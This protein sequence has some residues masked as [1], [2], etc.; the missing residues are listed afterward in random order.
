MQLAF[1]IR[2][3]LSLSARFL[4]PHLAILLALAAGFLLSSAFPLAS[5]LFLLLLALHAFKYFRSSPLLK[6]FVWHCFSGALPLV[7]WGRQIH[8]Q[9]VGFSPQDSWVAF[10]WVA[11]KS[12]VAP[13]R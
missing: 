7:P 11:C 5:C 10:S 2:L 9:S 4:L 6:L 3:L 1:F 12:L 8:R 13:G